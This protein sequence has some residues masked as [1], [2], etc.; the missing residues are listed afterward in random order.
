MIHY[1]A[2]KKNDIANGEGVRTSLFV[3]GCRRH[4]P[5]CFNKETWAFDAGHPFTNEVQQQ[6]IAS[7]SS[8]YVQ[9]LTI[10]GGEPLEEE[11]QA[12]LMPFLRKVKEACP[13]KSI[14]LYTGYIFDVDL[15][16]GG[17]KYTPV[18]NRILS[19]IDVLVDG[20]FIMEEKQLNLPYR[21]S[22]NQ[23]LL[24]MPSSLDS[25]SAVVLEL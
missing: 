10:L 19:M 4:C 5:H 6:I 9:G 20:P 2:I 25:G 21:G 17:S 11:N 24:D 12:G 1:S 23:R 7:L 13:T 14:W 16:P 22:R 18:T 15:Q 8:E 3:S